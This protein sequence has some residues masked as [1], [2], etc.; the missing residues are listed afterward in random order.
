MKI[1]VFLSI[2][3]LLAL[4]VLTACGNSQNTSAN[5]T[6]KVTLNTFNVPTSRWYTNEQ[7]ARGGILYQANCASCHKADVS[8][9]AN[10]KQ[11]DA[12]GKLPPPPLNGTAHAWHHPLSVLR[13]TVRLGGV[14]LGGTMPGFAGKLDDRELDD[15]L[16]WVQSHWSDEI[17]NIWIERDTQANQSLRKIN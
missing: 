16:A 17:Y 9:T 11:L 8:G 6:R 13:R 14:P 5:N 1:R 3:L 10:W 4:V 15:I 12:K 7:I 2:S